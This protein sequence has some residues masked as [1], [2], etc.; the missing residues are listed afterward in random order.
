MPN[1]DQV[2]LSVQE[3]GELVIVPSFAPQGVPGPKGDTGPAITAAAFIDNAIVFYRDDGS[4]VILPDAASVLK[5]E[6]APL[7]QVEYSADGTSFHGAYQA[8]DFYLRMSR[9]NGETWSGAIKFVG[10]DGTNG[11]DGKTWY[12][13]TSDPSSETGVNGD[14]YLNYTTWHVFEKISGS[15]TDKGTIKGA[16]GEDGEGIGLGIACHEEGTLWLQ[17]SRPF[18]MP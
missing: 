14:F 16:D 6:P 11:T 7:L 18:R 9:D 1:F 15:W 17:R 2:I 4:T 3:Q 13:G 5:G 8:G 12:R 10:T